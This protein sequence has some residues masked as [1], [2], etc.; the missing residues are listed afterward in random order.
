MKKV[1]YLKKII[2]LKKKN[3]VEKWLLELGQSRNLFGPNK[4]KDKN[5]DMIID[6]SIVLSNDLVEGIVAG[7]IKNKEI[8]EYN[9]QKT[10]VTEN[11]HNSEIFKG[12]SETTD[13]KY[14]Q[15]EK[16]KT[17]TSSEAINKDNN[18]AVSGTASCLKTPP[19][20]KIN[21][22]EFLEKAKR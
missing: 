14:M 7:K 13:P 8:T 2:Y 9:K 3:S 17:S 6:P 15:A 4:K 5:S 18:I 16:T 22:T 11:G 12:K 10:M 20:C 1:I 21:I 19:M